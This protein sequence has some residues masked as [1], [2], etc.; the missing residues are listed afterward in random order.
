MQDILRLEFPQVYVKD[1]KMACLVCK[2]IELARNY[3]MNIVENAEVK[4]KKTYL[5]SCCCD[6]KVKEEF[7]KC[8]TGHKICKSCVEQHI[9]ISVYESCNTVIKCIDCNAFNCDG[10]YED[11]VISSVANSFVYAEYKRLIHKKEIDSL[12]VDGINIKICHYCGHGVDVGDT[13]LTL[14]YC[15]NCDRNTCL[16]CDN[17]AHPDK[18]C[19]E[20]SKTHIADEAE[21]DN[22]L[23]TCL[24]C[25]RRLLKADGCNMITCVCRKIYCAT[26]KQ[27]ITGYK[28]F[29]QAGCRL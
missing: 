21:T 5:C 23:I 2:D 7:V 27:L 24:F 4:L 20:I 13:E 16:R 22:L 6:Q 12:C 10:V 18:P 8:S 14:L 28:H 26:C 17:A 19:A 25:K 11:Q 9:K 3:L 29:K 1:I 15:T